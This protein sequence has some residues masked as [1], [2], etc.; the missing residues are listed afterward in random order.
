MTI[1]LIYGTKLY[2][3]EMFMLVNIIMLKLDDQD[4]NRIRN[5]LSICDNKCDYSIF[6]V[7]FSLKYTMYIMIF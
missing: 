6:M 2:S 5:Y 7:A 4:Y 3:K 1:E